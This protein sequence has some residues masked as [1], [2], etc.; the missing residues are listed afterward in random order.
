MP[1]AAIPP[2]R[3]DHATWAR[4]WSLARSAWRTT[5][6]LADRL[7]LARTTVSEYCSGARHGDWHVLIRALR[8]SAREHPEEISRLVE[9]LAYEVL[10]ARGTWL[11][12]VD[13]AH[14]GS[15]AEEAGDVTIAA[16][17]LL[18]AHRRGVSDEAMRALI[19]DLQRETA[20]V[21]AVA[22]GGA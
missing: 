19:R 9:A 2:T 22:R 13:T 21:C 12:P 6:G 16:G 18:E 17:R 7:G 8:E 11:P 15:A 4:L 20:E 14:L 3:N 5:E 10:D 1:P